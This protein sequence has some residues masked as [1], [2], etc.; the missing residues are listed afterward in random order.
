M[1]P[2][3]SYSP[4]LLAAI[5]LGTLGALLLLAGLVALLRIRPLGFAL[6]T[7]AGLVLLLLGSLAGMIALGTQGYRALT[8]EDLAAR[9]FVK[10]GSAQRFS[11][12]IR[13]PDGRATAFDV[14]GDELYVDAHILKWKP[15]AGLLGLH[16]LFIAPLIDRAFSE[17]AITNRRVIIKVGF[18]SR[19]TLEMN[20]SK[21]E[22]VNVDQGIWGRMLG[23]G[24]ITIIGTGGTKETFGNI[25]GPL[26]FRRQFQQT[27]P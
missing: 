10:P 12:T 17:F 9:L 25:S 22:S 5:A 7:L 2:D 18:I 20:L 8:R 23:Y 24:T 13:F 1:A 11:V 27:S 3:L 26:E 15:L 21:I 14:A 6:H 16:T 4:L 19:K